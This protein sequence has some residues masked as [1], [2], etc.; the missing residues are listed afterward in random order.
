MLA[1]SV[2][3]DTALGGPAKTCTPKS[4]KTCFLGFTKVCLCP[5]GGVRF[6]LRCLRL[7]PVSGV[8]LAALMGS[9]WPRGFRAPLLLPADDLQH[10][11]WLS[12]LPIDV[13]FLSLEPI[14]G[15]NCQHLKKFL[16]AA[17]SH[18]TLHFQHVTANESDS[19]LC[20]Q[21]LQQLTPYQNPNVRIGV[22]ML[23]G[24]VERNCDSLIALNSVARMMLLISS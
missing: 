6:S 13:P 5:R 7:L 22:T 19:Q 17:G 1:F 11:K 4:A 12:S 16:G 10:C 2:S 15:F 9:V 3:G 23:E 18:G 8:V 24:T 14:T 21:L 20:G